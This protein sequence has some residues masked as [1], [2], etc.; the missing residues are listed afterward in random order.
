[1]PTA[2]QVLQTQFRGKNFEAFLRL[3]NVEQ[4]NRVCLG[5]WKPCESGV[6]MGT[7]EDGTWSALHAAMIGMR[8][9]ARFQKEGDR[10]L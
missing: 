8:K 9:I 1:M 4:R 7:M 5:G 6:G 2:A 3:S 10:K